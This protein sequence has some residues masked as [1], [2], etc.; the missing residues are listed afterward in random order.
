MILA[1]A[2]G[3]YRRHV[4]VLWRMPWCLL[5]IADSRASFASRHAAASAYD[6]TPKCCLP[7]GLARRLKER[8]V[9]GMSLLFD[10]NW[11]TLLRHVLGAGGKNSTRVMGEQ[12]LLQPL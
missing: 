10:A 11:T 3:I 12:E 9:A 7:D 6:K 1:T 4:L 2:A 8:G 5:H